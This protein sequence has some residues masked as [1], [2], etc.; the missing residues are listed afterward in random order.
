MGAFR[1]CKCGNQGFDKPTAREDL[2]EWER[3]ECG[4][5][6]R[7]EQYMS[8]QEWVIDLD[9]RLNELNHNP[10]TSV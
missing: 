6:E 1:Y 8:L 9:D 2:I 3:Q 5:G 7:L 4:C 10:K